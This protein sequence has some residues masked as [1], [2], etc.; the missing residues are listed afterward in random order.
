M[1]R[2]VY[3]GTGLLP[4]HPTLPPRDRTRKND[5]TRSVEPQAGGL[6][7]GKGNGLTQRV[8]RL[9]PVLRRMFR[10]DYYQT[11]RVVGSESL[12][13]YETP[14]E[15]SVVQDGRVTCQGPTDV[16]DP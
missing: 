4:V 13:P 15:L 14:E 12:R 3:L 5:R 11:S 6:E 9:P 10:L 1:G 8:L 2:Y 7:H 16:T